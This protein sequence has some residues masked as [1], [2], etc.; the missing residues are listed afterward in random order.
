MS[1]IPTDVT[2]KRNFKIK[3]ER[4]W[5]IT[6]RHTE[7]KELEKDD[8]IFVLG[9]KHAEKKS[10]GEGVVKLTSF[11]RN[12]ADFLA[13]ETRFRGSFD[14]LERMSKLIEHVNAYMR[15]T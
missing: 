12:I 8:L 7:I 1:H 13:K 10:H 4:Y 6:Q 15:K 11:A 14:S 5:F 3:R 2:K 9:K